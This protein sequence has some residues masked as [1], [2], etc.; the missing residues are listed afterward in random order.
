MSFSDTLLEWYDSHKRTLPWRGIHDPYKIWLS[1]VILQ[2]TQIAQGKDYYLRFIE[3]FPTVDLLAQAN[4]DEVM[5]LWEGLGYYSRARNLHFAAKQIVEIGYFPKEYKD[6]LALKGVGEYTAS[7]ISS[8][9]YNFPIATLDGNAYHV[10]GR[11]YTIE[12]PFDQT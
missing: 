4:E 7:A 6:I 1:E 8:M 3:R 9:A 11:I 10:Y 2:Q 5:K 12:Y